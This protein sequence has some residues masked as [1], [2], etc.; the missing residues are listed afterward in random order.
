MLVGIQ[1]KWM[2]SF[3][4]S[5][6]VPIEI[7]ATKAQQNESF[8]VTK[9]TFQTY[10]CFLQCVE[11]QGRTMIF[12]FER[13]ALSP[14]FLHLLVTGDQSSRTHPELLWWLRIRGFSRLRKHTTSLWVTRDSSCK[15]VNDFRPEDRKQRRELTSKTAD[16]SSRNDENLYC[17]VRLVLTV[18]RY[19]TRFLPAKLQAA[20]F[21]A[22]WGPLAVSAI[23][24]LPVEAQYRKRLGS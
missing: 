18:Q 16:A 5:T 14:S 15:Y 24:Y 4:W 17:L 2:R 3:I 6:A 22:G 7:C 11:T 12:I 8:S 9:P 10:I 19:E 13:N 1:L 23:N 20:Q 21:T